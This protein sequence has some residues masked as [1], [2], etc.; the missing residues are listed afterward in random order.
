MVKVRVMDI[1]PMRVL[2]KIDVQTCVCMCVY[3]CVCTHIREVIV[4]VIVSL[5]VNPA[6]YDLSLPP[7]SSALSFKLSVYMY[8]FYGV[9]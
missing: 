8:V 6:L 2:T 4:E 7:I 9:N 5:L 1:M 3:V